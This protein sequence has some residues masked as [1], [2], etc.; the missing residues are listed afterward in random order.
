MS[1][2]HPVQAVADTQGGFSVRNKHDGSVLCIVQCL[3]N[4]TFVDAVQIA[5]RLI[6][7]HERRIRKKGARQTDALL[8]AAGK[9]IPQFADTGFVAMGQGGNKIVDGCLF[10]RRND[11]LV[12]CAQLRNADVVA[13]GIVEQVRFLRA[14]AFVFAQG[15]CVDFC[16]IRPRKIRALLLKGRIQAVLCAE[17]VIKIDRFQHFMQSGIRCL[18]VA[19]EKI[20]SDRPLEE[21]AVVIDEGDS[22]HQAFFGNIGNCSLADGKTAEK[23]L[24]SAC[25]QGGNSGFAAAALTKAGLLNGRPDG[26]F[27]AKGKATRAEVATVLVKL[28]ELTAEK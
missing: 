19:H 15:F 28:A 1:V 2:F 6:Q 25:Q 21:I 9:R 8:F 4:D 5:G 14:V 12:R 16:D 20:F 26:S 13:D 18:G 27:D 11:F 17:K 3:Q 24:S 23:A 10:R 7:K 22:F